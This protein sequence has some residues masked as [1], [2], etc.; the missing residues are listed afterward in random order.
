MACNSRGEIEMSSSA[1]CKS[2][3][4]SGYRIL[5]RW[6]ISP[7]ASQVLKTGSSSVPLPVSLLYVVLADSAAVGLIAA[8]VDIAV[9]RTWL[10]HASIDTAAHYAQPNLA[11][12]HA[13]QKKLSPPPMSSKQPRWK[14][15]ADLMAWR[16][17]RFLRIT[18]SC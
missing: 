18:R 13:A 15:D 11:T 1:R 12:K 2:L 7:C 16:T 14:R 10:G 9:I 3:G 6:A 4:G 5:P 8:G 17:H